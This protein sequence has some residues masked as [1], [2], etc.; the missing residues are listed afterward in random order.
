MQAKKRPSRFRFSSKQIIVGIL[1][2]LGFWIFLNYLP[3]I[4][5]K[6][7]DFLNGVSTRDTILSDDAYAPSCWDGLIIGESTLEDVENYL[8]NTKHLPAWVIDIRQFLYGSS[9]YWHRPFWQE[10]SIFYFSTNQILQQVHWSGTANQMPIRDIIAIY[11]EPTITVAA[12]MYPVDTPVQRRGLSGAELYYPE[13]GMV[14]RSDFYFEHEYGEENYTVPANP[15]SSEI[16]FYASS[17]SLDELFHHIYPL[18]D[19]EDAEDMLAGTYYVSG[20]IGY[21]TIV[22][23][24]T[25]ELCIIMEADECTVSVPAPMR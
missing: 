6:L 19:F 10:S 25:T 11:G 23:D 20:W 15:T 12:F 21:G 7:I 1:L 22:P 5:L 18:S 13:Y 3:N 9:I 17:A 14:I 4:Y 16:R 8:Q 2:L 24:P